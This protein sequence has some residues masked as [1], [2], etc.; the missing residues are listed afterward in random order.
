MTS[1]LVLSAT[2]LGNEQKQTE[3]QED[4]VEVKD[5]LFL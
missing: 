5:I 1:L 2:L 3:N 4:L